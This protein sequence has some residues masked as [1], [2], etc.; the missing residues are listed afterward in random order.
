MNPTTAEVMPKVIIQEKAAPAAPTRAD[1]V[2]KKVS[3]KINEGSWREGLE[4]RKGVPLSEGK[5]TDKIDQIGIE[6]DADGKKVRTAGAGGD[7]ERYDKAIKA[8]NQIKNFVEKGYDGLSTAEKNALIARVLSELKSRPSLAAEITGMSGAEKIAQAERILRD[9]S[10]VEATR[11][12]LQDILETAPIDETSIAAARNAQEDAD[13]ELKEKEAERNEVDA[14]RIKNEN[15]MKQYERDATG[16]PLATSTLAVEMERLKTAKPTL[17]TELAVWN[18]EAKRLEAQLASLIRES[19]A[20]QK[21]GW[22][23]RATADILTDISTAE[24]NLA[25]AQ[26]QAAIRQAG[27]TRLTDLQTEEAT[28]EQRQAEIGSQLREKDAA[29]QKA[30]LELDRRTR[31]LE[32]LK[33]IRASQENDLV[34]GFEGVFETATG[35]WIAKQID[36]ASRLIDDELAKL[37]STATDGNEKAMYDALKDRYLA[38]ERT[39]KKGVYGFRSEQKYRPINRANVNADYA[40][41]LDKGPTDVMMSLLTSRENPSNPGHNYTEDEARKVLENKA[42]ADKM[43]PEVIKQLLARKQITGGF[44]AED[45]HAI[46]SAP[47]GEGALEKARTFN[48]TVQAEIEKTFGVGALNRHGFKERFGQLA[49]NKPWLIALIFGIPIIAVGALAM[50]ATSETINQQR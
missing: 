45:V 15:L 36:S 43:Q 35:E 48:A 47:W 8:A 49:R 28:L 25:T 38:P 13:L 20:S 46:L 26:E 2:A 21:K 1:E 29:F 17:E 44:T 31:T 22:T 14:R 9:P 23:G 6:R 10:Y 32:D 33:A 5:I 50:E 19:Q 24:G 42:F 4:I 39:R 27:L 34:S 11:K 37:E 7:Q 41:L 18:G 30:K 3:E 12:G 16:T 40:T